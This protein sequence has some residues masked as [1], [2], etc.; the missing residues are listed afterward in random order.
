MLKRQ[1]KRKNENLKIGLKTLGMVLFNRSNKAL[2]KLENN[3]RSLERKINQKKTKLSELNKRFTETKADYGAITRKMKKARLKLQAVVMKAESTNG[4]AI[5]TQSNGYASG[6][7]G[8]KEIRSKY[9]KLPDDQLGRIE[10]ERAIARYLMS[11]NSGC[12]YVSQVLKAMDEFYSLE[13]EEKVMLLDEIKGWIDRD[14]LCK[15]SKTTDNVK[16]YS[17]I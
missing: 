10:I 4:H 11:R 7:N 12:F 14:P 5:E 16:H 9:S 13:P 8:L 3:V 17:L 1:K 15:L 2:R 6:L